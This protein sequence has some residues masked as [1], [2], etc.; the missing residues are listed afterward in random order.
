M[1]CFSR[2]VESVTATRIFARGFPAGAEKERQFIVYSMHVRAA[3]ELAM[4]LPIPAKSGTGENAARFINLE[5]YSGLFA[6][7]EKGFP[8]ER[9]W[10]FGCSKTADKSA[11]ATLAVHTRGDW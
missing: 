3:E 6:D 8:P 7:L 5:S 1:C 4:V 10:S 9:H 2:P 11:S